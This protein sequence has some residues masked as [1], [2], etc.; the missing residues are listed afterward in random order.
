MYDPKETN[1]ANFNIIELSIYVC[2]F[3]CVGG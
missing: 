1:T 3:V 2:V